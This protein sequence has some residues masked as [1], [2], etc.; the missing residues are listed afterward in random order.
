MIFDKT[1][2]NIKDIVSVLIQ[3]AQGVSLLGK[4][5]KLKESVYEVN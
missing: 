2:E 5:I 4:R 3:D 1:T